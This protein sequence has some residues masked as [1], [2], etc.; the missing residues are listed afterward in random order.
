MSGIVLIIHVVVCLALII[1]VLLQAGNG[2]DM[3]A[4]FGGAAKAVPLGAGVAAPAST[5]SAEAMGGLAK[6]PA[7]AP[8]G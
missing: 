8:E 1:I 3:G 6:R 5:T 4:A 7:P 2:A